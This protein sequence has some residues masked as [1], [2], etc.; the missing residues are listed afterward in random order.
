VQN[1]FDLLM[2]WDVQI[3]SDIVGFYAFRSNYK[4][5]ENLFQEIANKREKPQ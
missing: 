4:F 2:G 5:K 1:V 3:V